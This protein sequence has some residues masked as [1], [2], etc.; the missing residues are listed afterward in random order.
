MLL[1]LVR[2][3]IPNYA[4]DSLTPDGALQAEAVGKRLAATGID[5]IY[6]SP[7]GRARQTAEPTARLLSKEINIENWMSESICA[8]SFAGRNSEGKPVTW[9]FWQKS[10]LI[11]SDLCYEDRDSFSHGYYYNDETAKAGAKALG[12]A[13]D[14]FLL[15]LGFRKRG[16]GNSYEVVEKN[17]GRIA[18]FA[19]Q[20]FGLHWLSYLTKIPYHI[21]TTSF[22]ISHTGVTI[23]HFDE[24]GEV[25][26]PTVLT[27][28]DLSHIYKEGLP[29]KYHNSI[30]I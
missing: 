19:H 13:S 12:E 11:G 23:I 28:S 20:G 26:Y 2:H 24:S 6:S 3:G 8:R 7:L 15:R 22:D 21:L 14:E 4:T 16:I 25:T 10:K 27:L 1:Y 9:A 5:E 18:V 29:L 30:E 17:S